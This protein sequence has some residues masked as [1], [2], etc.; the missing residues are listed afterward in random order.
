[1]KALDVGDVLLVYDG[2]SFV[3]KGIQFFMR[4]YRRKK[5]IIT[6]KNYHHS[7]NVIEIWGYLHIAEAIGKGYAV[8]KPLKAYSLNSWKTRVHILTPIKP[9]KESEKRELSEAATGYSL[10]LTR[11]DYF[12]F[13]FQIWLIMTGKW[14]GPKGKK[15]ENRFYCSEATA[16]LANIIRPGTFKLPAATNPI[17][18]AINEHYRLRTDEEM[19]CLYEQLMNGKIE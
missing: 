14:I 17:D 5:K 3:A 16:T 15:A 10:K 8:N 4:K 19:E 2:S 6:L 12:N 1:M 11:Y 18:V 13:L 9:Y 7:A